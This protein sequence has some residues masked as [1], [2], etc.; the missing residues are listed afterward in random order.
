[1]STNKI[2]YFNLRL[3]ALKSQDN[4]RF[5]G[6]REVE[7]LKRVLS[8]DPKFISFADQHVVDLGCG[9]QYLKQAFEDCGANYRGIDI[10]ECNLEFQSFP[11]LVIRKILPFAS[12]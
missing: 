10:D 1:M 11:L 12:H 2:G 6:E 8:N 4:R 5:L 3:R 9:D 7:T